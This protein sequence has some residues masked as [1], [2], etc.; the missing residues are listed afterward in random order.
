MLK[1]NPRH[2]RS[3]EL[4]PLAG[5]EIAPMGASELRRGGRQ[6]S[7][8]GVGCLI[9]RWIRRALPFANEMAGRSRHIVGW[10]VAHRI[11]R[12]AQWGSIIHD[13]SILVFVLDSVKIILGGGW[14]LESEFGCN[15][16]E[17]YRLNYTRILPKFGKT[18][19]LHICSTY[20]QMNLGM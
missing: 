10:S 11:L 15:K 1:P 7:L 16:D 19:T 14:T 20:I 17:Y 13:F 3:Q 8:G 18:L 9:T 4:S 6:T 5:G 12:V 2:L